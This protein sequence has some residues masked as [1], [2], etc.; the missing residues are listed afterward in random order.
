MEPV[1]NSIDDVCDLTFAKFSLTDDGE[2]Y[3]YFNE[4]SSIQVLRELPLDA[5]INVINLFS[6]RHRIFQKID[7]IKETKNVKEFFEIVL[8]LVEY[9][10]F[11]ATDLTILIDDQIKLSSYDDGEV[12]LVSANK[13]FLHDLIKKL[14]IRQHYSPLLLTD[15]I[16]R[17]NLYHKLQRPDKI[18]SSYSTLDE[19]IDAM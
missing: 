2:E 16:D 9:G 6:E 5:A 12:Q 19:V 15:I 17:P 8:P 1:F 3:F 4:Q 11:P 14:I 18:I 10:N 7:A 13:H